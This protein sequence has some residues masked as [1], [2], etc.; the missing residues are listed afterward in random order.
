[1]NNPFKSFEKIFCINLA[2]RQ[3]RWSISEQHF[4]QLEIDNYERINAVKVNGN[5]SP[6]RKGQI[7]CALSFT[8][9]IDKIIK[10]NL[11]NS[12]ILED[13]FE[14]KLEKDLLFSKLEKC[15]N[16]LP[17]DWDSL[18]LGGTVGNFYGVNPLQ[19]YS[20]NLFKLNCAYTTHAIAF[21]NK[22]AQKIKEI[23]QNDENWRNKIIENYEAI[24]IFLAKDYLIQTNSFI[25]ND[26]LCYQRINHSNIECNTYDYSGLMDNNFQ[27]FKSKMNK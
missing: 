19:N 17:L 3:D 9:C 10:G 11:K 6:K 22:G 23:F 12:L 1:M 14:F 27:F 15:L 24:D 20:S 16:E 25:T 13:D 26:L 5:I 7:G 21:S 2:E 18:Y 8:F 4:K